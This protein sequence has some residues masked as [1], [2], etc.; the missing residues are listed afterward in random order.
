MNRPHCMKL[1]FILTILLSL[2]PLVGRAQFRT[3]YHELDDSETVQSFK[4]HISTL[5]SSLMEG[6]KAGSEGERLAADYVYSTLQSYGVDMLCRPE[7]DAFGIAR[8]G[9]D[10]LNSQNII[11]V[12]QGY[13]HSICDRYIVVGARLD[14]LGTN[15]MTIDGKSVTQTYFGANGNASGLALMMELAKMVSTNAILFRRSVIFV[16]F[17]A[18]AEAYAGAWYFLNRSFADAGKI[19]AMINLDMVGSGESFYAYTSSNESMDAIVRRLEGQLQPVLPQLTT[20]EPYPSDHRAFY[21]KK[22]PSVLFTTGRYPEYNTSRDTEGIIDYSLMER[23]LEYVY[24]FT[25]ELANLRTPPSFSK[26]IDRTQTDGDKT[27][28]YYDCTEKPLFMGH[29]DLRWFLSKWVYQYLRY[30]QQALKDGI[31]GVVNVEF[32]VDKDG[33]L[34]DVRVTKSVD[35]DLDAEALRVIKASPKWTAGKRNGQKVKC[36]INLPVEFKLAKKGTGKL[37]IKK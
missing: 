37:K 29:A 18:S 31:Q 4:G 27:V 14:N 7:G 34:T 5:A 12:V 21:S 15:Q 19:D 16:A 11:G 28:S 22:I 25:R 17:G 26:D 13:D 10:T 8:E 32:A 9:A 1:R 30:P 6:R 23:E 36:Y 2:L 33:K 3:G 24:N 35:P 20:A